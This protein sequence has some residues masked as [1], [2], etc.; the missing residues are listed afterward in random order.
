MLM[1]MESGLMEYWRKKY[2]SVKNYCTGYQTYGTL[3]R[4]L[5]IEDIRSAFIV[6]FVGMTIAFITLVAEVIS[7]YI[8]MLKNKFV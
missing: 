6:W 8:F 1:M 7:Y 5:T 2:L 4:R 3:L